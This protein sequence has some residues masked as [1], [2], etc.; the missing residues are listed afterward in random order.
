MTISLQNFRNEISHNDFAI[1][2]R[3]FA[4]SISLARIPQNF[5]NTMQLSAAVQMP[6]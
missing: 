5:C 6:R 2:N 3:S 1:R 4:M